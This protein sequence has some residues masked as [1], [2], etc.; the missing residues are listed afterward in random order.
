M[1]NSI[2]TTNNWKGPEY[3]KNRK[4]R[5]DKVGDKYR[6]SKDEKGTGSSWNTIKEFN[7]QNSA[8]EYLKKQK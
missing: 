2:T 4:Y 3:H 8:R 5:L 6:V 1:A 7:G